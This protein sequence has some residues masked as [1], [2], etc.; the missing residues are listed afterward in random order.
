M[1]TARILIVI[2]TRSWIFNTNIAI[3]LHNVHA[4]ILWDKILCSNVKANLWTLI[5]KKRYILLYISMKLLLTAVSILHI[6][7][8][9]VNTWSYS[10][11]TFFNFIFGGSKKWSGN[12]TEW[13]HAKMIEVTAWTT[14]NTDIR[15]DRLH[16]SFI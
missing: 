5:F 1:K 14:K 6:T 12:E 10:Q 3:L 2:N 16:Y 7:M 9:L 13:I 11:T 8:K 15:T 4:Y